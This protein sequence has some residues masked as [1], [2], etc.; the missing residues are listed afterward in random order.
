MVYKALVD[1]SLNYGLIVW[2]AAKKFNLYTLK[3]I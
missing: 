1:Y 3:I 2:G